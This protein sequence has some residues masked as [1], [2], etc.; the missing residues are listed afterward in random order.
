MPKP[1]PY[2]LADGTTKRFKIRYRKADGKSTDKGG[3]TSERDA[4]LW[5][6]E[7]LLAKN[8]GTYT[9]P[10]QRKK[11]LKEMIA[12][13]AATTV[14]LR[15]TTIATRQSVVANWV[16]PK[17]DN[18][19][20]AAIRQHDVE[21]WIEDM[22]KEGAGAATIQKAHGALLAILRQ[23]MTA[24][25][26]HKNPA[27]GVKVPAVVVKP[28]LYLTHE[29]VAELAAAVEPRAKLV[30]GMLAYVGLR[31]G[32]L[33]ALRVGSIN[34]ATRRI[35]IDRSITTVEGRLVEGPPKGGKSRDA[36]YPEFLS[37]AVAAQT[38]GKRK[39]DFLFTAAQGGPL[40]L[41]DWRGRVFYTATA[42]ITAE[43]EADA[44]KR[45]LGPAEP[46]P[47][48]TPH[49]LRHTAASLAVQ[50]GA[51]IKVLQRILGHESASLTLDRYAGLFNDDL[52]AVSDLL[53]ERVLSG[54]AGLWSGVTP[55]GA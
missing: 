55:E 30:I 14:R 19:A 34:R 27:E 47:A 35:E 52:V 16:A 31:F 53:N 29:E 7:T 51:N 28:N 26:I 40:R 2:T 18:W 17:W 9:S 11:R 42:K 49:D 54:G 10:T 22:L 12:R 3:F 1:L 38:A 36:F 33:A 45:N 41:D 46:F 23:A 37:E 43:R 5:F 39:A 48:V 8:K 13:Y 20:A 32:E 50:A 25:L 21:D 4:N 24:G 6:A 44:E 15:P